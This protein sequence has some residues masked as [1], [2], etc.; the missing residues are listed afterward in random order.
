MPTSLDAGADQQVPRR[1]DARADG[2]HQLGD[3]RH[4]GRDRPRAL[5]STRC[6]APPQHARA[7]RF[8]LC[9]RDRRDSIATHARASPRRRPRIDRLCRLP[10]HPGHGARRRGASS[11]SAS[12]T[13]S[14]RP[15]TA[16][17]STRA[18]AYP[19]P[20]TRPRGCASS[21]AGRSMSRSGSWDPARAT[22]RR[23]RNASPRVSVSSR[24]PCALLL[25]HT[26]I[27]PY[28]MGSRG[29]RGAAA[30]G[31]AAYLAARRA[32]RRCSRSRR[33]SWRS[34]P[35]PACASRRAASSG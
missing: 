15:P 8:P 6:G 1:P 7:R 23:S 22:R 25:G 33:I 18:R 34:T 21:R 19:A 28:G 35:R 2:D 11:A 31:G 27:A 20:A 17:N 26:D 12:A 16:R 29:S 30:G 9:D 3:R 10:P 4:D 24:R 5:D 32:A 13:S 14:N